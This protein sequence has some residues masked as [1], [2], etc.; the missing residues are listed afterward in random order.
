MNQEFLT[1]AALLGLT[2]EKANES[3]VSAKIQDLVKASKEL[4]TLKAEKKA[5]EKRLKNK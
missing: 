3:A 1:V 2:G 4:E 5:L